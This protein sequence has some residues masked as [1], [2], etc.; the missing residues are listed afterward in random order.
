M[1][2]YIDNYAEKS[3]ALIE[4]T[5]IIPSAS[6]NFNAFITS[7][8]DSLSSNWTEE[9]V[10]G[11]QD[12]IGTFQNTSRKISLSF[13]LPASNLTDAK[14]NLTKVNEVKQFMY[15]AYHTSIAPPA[16]SVVTRNA[17]SLAKSPLVRLKFANLIQNGSGKGLLGWIGSFSATPVIDMGMFSEGFKTKGMF[18]PK[19]YNV[20]LDFTPQH[21]YDLGWNSTEKT[22]VS[23]NF[24]KFPY[25]GGS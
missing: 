21:E 14:K 18:F 19:V 10:Y 9:Q 11:R 4:I 15:P 20:S 1:T 6:V 3:G 8:N 17:L 22:P 5:G 16:G 24:T 7:F 2:S 12:P 13:D 25:D 23:D